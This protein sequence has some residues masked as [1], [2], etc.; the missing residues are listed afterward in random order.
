VEI[1]VLMP[2]L[3]TSN[4]PV[5]GRVKKRILLLKGFQSLALKD[6]GLSV[7]MLDSQGMHA[8]S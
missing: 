7:A 8:L 3:T 6:R 1:K 5:S 2:P 4:S